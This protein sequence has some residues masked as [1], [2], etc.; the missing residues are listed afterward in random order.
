MK[1]KDCPHYDV[2]CKPDIE[3]PCNDINYSPEREEIMKRTGG[4]VVKSVK[5]QLRRN[6][7]A[8]L[9]AGGTTLPT[10]LDKIRDKTL[11]AYTEAALCYRGGGWWLLSGYA[12]DG[13][14]V[15]ELIIALL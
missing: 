4:A 14:D 9:L 6:A 1:I 10:V 2:C 5:L 13:S 3:C 12:H 8:K 11:L 7:V 15:N